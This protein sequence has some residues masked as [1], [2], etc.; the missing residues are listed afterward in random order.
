MLV[1]ENVTALAAFALCVA[2][3][4]LGYLLRNWTDGVRAEWAGVFAY[5]QRQRRKQAAYRRLNNG[6]F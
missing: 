2:A 5:R 1:V 6:G 4:A 3:F